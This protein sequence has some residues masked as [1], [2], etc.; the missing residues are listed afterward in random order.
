MPDQKEAFVTELHQQYESA[1]IKSCYRHVHYDSRYL[2][3][4]EDCVQ[5]AFLLLFEHDL[6]LFE[7]E[8]FMAVWL[9]GW[10]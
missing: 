7:H 3:L 2:D 9:W 5:D 1:L 8:F 6:L 4:A 10:S